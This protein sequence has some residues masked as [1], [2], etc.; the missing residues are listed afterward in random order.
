[1]NEAPAKWPKQWF[2]GLQNVA[3]GLQGSAVTKPVARVIELVLR[4]VLAATFPSETKIHRTVHFG[5]SALGVVLNRL[6]VIEEHCLIGSH[7]VLGGKWPIRGA[8]YIEAYATIH[9]GA[10]VIGPVR[11][12]RGAVIGAN[13]VVTKDIPPFSV[14][15]GVP[16]RVIKTLNPD[17][18]HE[19]V[20]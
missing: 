14:A 9:A 10:K 11:I 3:H 13:A 6:C 12:G 4:L 8:P 15:V 17:Q 19:S 2:V 5:H 18:A 7:V 16:A 20:A 1:M